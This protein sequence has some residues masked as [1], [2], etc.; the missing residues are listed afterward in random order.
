[1]NKQVTG[2]STL[3]RCGENKMFGLVGMF[4]SLIIN[5]CATL[6]ALTKHGCVGVVGSLEML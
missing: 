4:P 6:L 2:H 1:M 3:F 5:W